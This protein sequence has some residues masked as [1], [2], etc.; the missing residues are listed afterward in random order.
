M[1]RL[2]LMSVIGIVVIVAVGIA[3]FLG[4]E[5]VAPFYT[6]LGPTAGD[7]LGVNA[8]EVVNMELGLFLTAVSVLVI[9]AAIAISVL[10]SGNGGGAPARA[11]RQP[12]R[13]P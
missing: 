4:I 6:E 13:R 12:P 1:I 7:G 5:I 8:I 9:P 3:L 10:V 2:L 11:P